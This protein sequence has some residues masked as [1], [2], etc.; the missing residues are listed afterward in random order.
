MEPTGDW[1]S[2]TW[3]RVVVVGVASMLDSPLGGWV[4]G[5]RLFGSFKA[6]E[7]WKEKQKAEKKAK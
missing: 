4:T 1:W 6:A 3:E 2:I 7:Q 5:N